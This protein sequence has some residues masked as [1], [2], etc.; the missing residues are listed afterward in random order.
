MNRFD[1]TTSNAE[2]LSKKKKKKW[3]K[4]VVWKRGFFWEGFELKRAGKGSLGKRVG[5]FFFFFSVLFTK[6]N[7]DQRLPDT[8]P[9]TR[10]N[11]S[12]EPN[13]SISFINVF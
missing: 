3:G 1:S 8:K 7:H 2:I 10:N 12:I 9:N 13:Q 11:T 5:F 4:R 6:C